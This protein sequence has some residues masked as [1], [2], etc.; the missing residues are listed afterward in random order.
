[1][2]QSFR[3]AKGMQKDMQLLRNLKLRGEYVVF[4]EKIQSE[5]D[6]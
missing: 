6:D 1:M 3:L 2:G 4:T 5:I